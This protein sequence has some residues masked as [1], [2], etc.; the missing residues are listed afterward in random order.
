[1]NKIRYFSLSKVNTSLGSNGGKSAPWII[2]FSPSKLNTSLGSDGG[3][4]APWI[5]Y[6][7][8]SQPNTSTSLGSNER[9]KKCFAL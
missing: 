5:I 9:N 4:L 3:K 6:F 2:Y 8:P 1:M 7:L